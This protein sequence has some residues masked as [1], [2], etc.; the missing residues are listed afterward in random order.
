MSV[1]SDAD[2]GT[3][4]DDSLCQ[5]GLVVLPTAVGRVVVYG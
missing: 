5:T 3:V 2:G 4:S 1:R